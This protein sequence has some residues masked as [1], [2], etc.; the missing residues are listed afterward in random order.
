M[1]LNTTAI[2]RLTRDLLG[3]VT[4]D[5]VNN[6]YKVDNEKKVAFASSA[7]LG[8][9]FTKEDPIYD[10][11]CSHD[12]DD[13]SCEL[14]SGQYSFEVTKRGATE[15]P[16]SQAFK[17]EVSLMFFGAV[18]GEQARCDE[19][20]VCFAGDMCRLHGVGVADKY[21]VPDVDRFLNGDVV[22]MREKSKI[23]AICNVTHDHQHRT[24]LVCIS[25]NA[26]CVAPMYRRKGIAS[27]LMQYIMKEY[28]A[29]QIRLDILVD[30]T[31]ESKRS[32][33]KT[34]GFE[35]KGNRG[36]EH[37]LWV[38]EAEE[39]AV[40]DWWSDLHPKIMASSKYCYL[41][42]RSAGPSRIDAFC[43]TEDYRNR[44]PG[45]DPTMIQFE[46]SRY[47]GGGYNY[48]KSTGGGGWRAA[49]GPA[50]WWARA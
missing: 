48:F 13:W 6:V 28:R 35:Y 39:E 19:D 32:F 38:Y 16:F 27:A 12:G 5:S 8:A 22:V 25:I 11:N 23:V 43:S 50:A 10:C 45:L 14:N 37:E 31:I 15:R 21:K 7:D 18:Q 41:R 4:L 9:Q 26:L 47:T 42:S 44:N 17:D 20:L 33:Y 46:Q 36:P 34:L 1:N 29:E 2:T 49:A 40:P 3:F 24:D 30:K